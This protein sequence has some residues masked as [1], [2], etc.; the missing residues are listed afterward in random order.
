MAFRTPEIL[1]DKNTP[2]LYCKLMRDLFLP[3]D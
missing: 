2:G 1:V 3:L